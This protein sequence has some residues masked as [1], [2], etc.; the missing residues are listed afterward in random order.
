MNELKLTDDERQMLLE[1][2]RIRQCLIETG[3]P[4]W[5]A[6]EAIA[7][8]RPELVLTLQP[9]QRSLLASLSTLAARLS[10]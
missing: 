6:Q 9:P 8:G 1:A 10:Q 4:A 2:L 7:A 3:H 5:T